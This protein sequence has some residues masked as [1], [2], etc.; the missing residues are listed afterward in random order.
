MRSLTASEI[1]RIAGL[2][3]A[4]HDA[5]RFEQFCVVLDL[6]GLL[7]AAITIDEVSRA[8][9]AVKADIERRCQARYVQV[10]FDV[11]RGFVCRRTDHI[12]RVGV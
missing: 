9:V 12:Q 11:R 4:H 7:Q 1:D 8:F 6:M 5:D 3:V 2:L 10:L